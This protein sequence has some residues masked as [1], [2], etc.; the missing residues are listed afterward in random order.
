M[1]DT[2]GADCWIDTF[3]SA[4]QRTSLLR[5]LVWHCMAGKEMGRVRDGHSRKALLIT[6]S[7]AQ[8]GGHYAPKR[9]GY[10][11]E[12]S[13]SACPR[14][15]NFTWSQS[16]PWFWCVTAQLLVKAS[17]SILL[18]SVRSHHLACESCNNYEVKSQNFSI[19]CCINFDSNDSNYSNYSWTIA[20]IAS[21][22]RTISRGP[23]RWP[24]L[25]ATEGD[26][27][28]RSEESDWPWKSWPDE[29]IRAFRRFPTIGVPQ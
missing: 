9:D 19:S 20:A 10:C 11:Q 18:F 17:F 12:I 27:R 5:L 14:V 16:F 2:F 3:F 26:L 8:F 29:D 1:Q 28:S 25:V 23:G 24:N 22:H 15:W 6:S 13:M 7:A 21:I 4:A